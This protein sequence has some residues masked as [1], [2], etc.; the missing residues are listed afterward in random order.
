MK[1]IFCLCLGFA[2]SLTALADDKP[3]DAKAL[4]GVWIPVKA[5]L[6]GQPMSDDVLKTITLE[7]KQNEYAVYVAGQPD[8]GTWTLDPSAKPKAM[9]ITGVK[10]PNAGKTFPAIYELKA[11]VLRICY[12]LSGAK[13]P[14]EFKT[15]PGTK[16]YLVTYNRKR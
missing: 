4:Q 5:E 2:I 14:S 3:G 6:S 11:D 10:G 9:K 13:R 16:L 15:S 7:L 1:N 12:D 8:L